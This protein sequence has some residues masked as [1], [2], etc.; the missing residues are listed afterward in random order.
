[1]NLV[2]DGDG[3]DELEVEDEPVLVLLRQNLS[4]EAFFTHFYSLACI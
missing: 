3:D 2:L 1:M 4:Q